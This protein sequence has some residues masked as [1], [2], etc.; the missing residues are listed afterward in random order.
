[1]TTLTPP[2]PGTPYATFTAS[3]SPALSAIDEH[4][5]VDAFKTHGALLLRGFDVDMAAF[6]NLTRTLCAN[7]VFNESPGRELLDAENNI[8]TVNTGLEAFPL[9]PELSREPWKPDAC[10]FWCMS[11]P[12]EGGETTVCDGVEVVKNLPADVRAAFENRRLLYRQMASPELLHYW[13]GTATPDDAALTN[14][15][16]GCPYKFAR[17]NGGVMRY[18][19][20]PALHRPMFASEPAWGNFLLFARAQGRRGFP[21]FENGQ[22]V[23]DPLVAHVKDVSDRLSAPIQWRRNDII[24]LDNTRFMH[25]R[26][27]I[28][29]AGERRIA[30]YFGYLKFAEPDA[31]EAEGAPWRLREAQPA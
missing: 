6:R 3:G 15:P 16:R 5:L 30:T 1:M 17:S 26:N 4:T 19:S 12:T 25:G 21:A 18:F 14:P 27:R 20:R 9:H 8:Q 29:D 13:F 2:S 11:P 22:P 7:S 31:E 23:P 28:T 24:I 10:F